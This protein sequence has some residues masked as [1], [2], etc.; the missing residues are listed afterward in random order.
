MAG[1]RY[2]SLATNL[3]VDEA[4]KCVVFITFFKKAT[5]ITISMEETVTKMLVIKKQI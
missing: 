2:V 1:G 3:L 4:V 5:S